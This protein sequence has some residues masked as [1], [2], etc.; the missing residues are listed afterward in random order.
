MYDSHIG[1]KEFRRLKS[2]VAQLY[3]SVNDE[4]PEDIFAEIQECYRVGT[5][6]STQYDNLIGELV[7]LGYKLVDLGY[8]LMEL[9]GTF[10]D[11]DS[12]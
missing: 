6:S 9:K 1:P 2:R 12:K 8:N 4:D 7:D 3:Y 10:I 11:S 5:L